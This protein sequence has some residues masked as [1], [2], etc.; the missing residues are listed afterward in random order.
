MGFV[1]P[2]EGVIMQKSP[3]E[4][5]LEL[6]AAGAYIEQVSEA[7]QAFNIRIGSNAARLPGG[8]VQQLFAHRRIRQSCRV[9][10]RMRYVA[11]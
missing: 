10:G 9:S 11:T 3:F 1:R 4:V 6:L 2:K 7:P 5:V 8:L